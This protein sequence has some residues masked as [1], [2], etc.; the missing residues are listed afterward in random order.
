M[1]DVEDGLSEFPHVVINQA[2]VH[3]YYLEK[4]HRSPRR[5]APDYGLR[6]LD[7]NIDE[8]RPYPV[9]VRLAHG[10]ADSSVET[11]NARYVVGCDGARSAVRR[12][13]NLKLEGESA[14][15]AWGVM[16]V[17]AVTSFPDVRY[18]VVVRSASE[19][20][21][22]IIPREGGY[23]FRLYLELDQL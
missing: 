1:Q 23:L 14:N 11:I 19:G 7:L 20:N 2:R 3:D 10:D 17:L 6:F 4:M 21:A 9:E 15:Q 12:S 18:K 13:V 5:L 22:L 16:D 8:S